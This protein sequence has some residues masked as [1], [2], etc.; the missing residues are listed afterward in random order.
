M[1]NLLGI[2]KE[3]TNVAHSR[4]AEAGATAAFSGAAAQSQGGIR[5]LGYDSPLRAD[6][7]CEVWRL[8]LVLVHDE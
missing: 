6:N 2:H 4:K 1:S 7:A 5:K 8:D 3:L